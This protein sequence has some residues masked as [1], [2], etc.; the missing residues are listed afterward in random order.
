MY[1]GLAR[2]AKIAMLPDVVKTMACLPTSIPETTYEE[3]LL[4]FFN[5]RRKSRGGRAKA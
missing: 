5:R 2:S 1:A 3:E 4:G